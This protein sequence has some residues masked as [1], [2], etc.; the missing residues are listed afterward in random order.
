MITGLCVVDIRGGFLKIIS[1]GIPTYTGMKTS[2]HADVSP[3]ND[4]GRNA[5]WNNL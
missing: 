5:D 2:F 4:V 3:K 1:I